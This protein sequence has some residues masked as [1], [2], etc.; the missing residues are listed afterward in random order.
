M[1]GASAFLDARSMC[2]KRT[3]SLMQGACAFP[4]YWLEAFPARP[5]ASRYV[6]TQSAFKKAHGS[7]G[8][9]K[10]LS[11]LSHTQSQDACLHLLW[12]GAACWGA[13]A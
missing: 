4:V 6:M 11:I 3:H 12:P 5:L 1:Q 7:K 10:L 9:R 8:M 13:V 2:I